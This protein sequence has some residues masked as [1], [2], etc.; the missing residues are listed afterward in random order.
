MNTFWQIFF[1][2]GIPSILVTVAIAVFSRKIKQRDEE[3]EEKEKAKLQHD[4]MMTEMTMAS[5]SLAEATAKAVQR[6]PD[7][8]CNGDMH[9]ALDYATTVKNKYKDFERI[10]TIK[11]VS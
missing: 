1:S 4:V 7:A 6:I 10:Q 3:R 9:E 8:K 11:S 2:A 5:M